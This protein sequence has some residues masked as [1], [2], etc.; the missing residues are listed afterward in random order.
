[1]L[2]YHS[3]S[4]Y[5]D[6]CVMLACKRPSS[7]ADKACEAVTSPTTSDRSGVRRGIRAKPDGL[8]SVGGGA[9]NSNG[10][11]VR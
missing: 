1:M 11:I 7:Q 5:E 9:V 3:L 10:N 2:L 4:F 8:R 6:G